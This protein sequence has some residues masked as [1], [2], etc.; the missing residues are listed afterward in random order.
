[1]RPYQIQVKNATGE[2][3]C[4]NIGYLTRCEAEQTLRLV[5]SCDDLGREYRLIEVTCNVL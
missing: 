1:M 4:V 5:R 2:W 3:E